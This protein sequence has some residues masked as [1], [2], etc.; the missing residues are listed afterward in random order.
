MFELLQFYGF[1][2]LCPCSKA[3]ILFRNGLDM[4]A[5]KER[6]IALL[7]LRTTVQKKKKER[8]D[9]WLWWII[10]V[11]C[12]VGIILIALKFILGPSVSLH[13]IFVIIKKKTQLLINHIAYTINKVKLIKYNKNKGGDIHYI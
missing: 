3:I 10:L 13:N 2:G 9:I 7:M 1:I 11:D 12:L 4:Q 8:M 6:I 5:E